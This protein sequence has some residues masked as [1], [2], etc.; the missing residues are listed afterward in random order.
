MWQVNYGNGWE[1]IDEAGHGSDE[2]RV[3]CTRRKWRFVPLARS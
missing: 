3:A 1:P 2:R